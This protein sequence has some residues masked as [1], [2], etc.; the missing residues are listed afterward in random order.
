MTLI[1]TTGNLISIKTTDIEDALRILQT[2]NCQSLD[3]S[4]PGWTDTFQLSEK[5]D[6][7]ISHFVNNKNGRL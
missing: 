6:Y 2:E 3:A 4:H 5:I 7:L 1:T